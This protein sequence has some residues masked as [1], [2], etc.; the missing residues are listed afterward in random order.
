[1]LDYCY[2]HPGDRRSWVVKET[3]CIF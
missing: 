3:T 2:Q 1:M